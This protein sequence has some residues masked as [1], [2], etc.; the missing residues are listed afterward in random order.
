MNIL[1]LCRGNVGRSQMAEWLFKKEFG[2]KYKV[3]SAGTK[4]SGPEEPIGNLTPAINEVID[5]MKEEGIDVSNSIRK[6]VTEDMVNSADKVVAILEDEELP[7][8]LINS[9]KLVRWHVI[10]P[11][12]KDLDETRRIKDEIKELITQMD[13]E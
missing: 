9:P 5:V 6:Q 7:D 3:T 4:L 12:G 2:E 13:I 1:F 10:D 8:Y 11:K